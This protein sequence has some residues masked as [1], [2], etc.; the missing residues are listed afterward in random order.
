MTCTSEGIDL[1]ARGLSW[2][3][4][5]GRKLVDD[6]SFT[7]AAGER[8]A[9]VGPN[10]AGKS[11]LLRLLYRACRP[12]RGEVLLGG[13]DIW[14]IRPQAFARKV[15]VVLQENQT[16]FPFSVRDVV[17]MGRIPWRR[18]L[19]HWSDEDRAATRHALG[20]LELEDL[21]L[22]QFP[23]LSGGEKQ[24]VLIARALAQSPRLLVLDEP[25]NHLDI[26]HQLEILDILK[27]LG[28][29]VIATLHDINL[30]TGFATRAAV[31]KD[32]QMIAFGNPD[33]V[34]TR[35]TIA[36]AFDVA[37]DRH[38]RSDGGQH[39]SFSIASQR[40]ARP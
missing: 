8:L 24:R 12:D 35:G 28:I 9:I 4:K 18:G 5:G 7:L 20:H 37:A 33:D 3:P 2:A 29:T 31:M 15:A 26:R 1:A 39:F 23:S 6:I 16:V 30:A 13:E 27:G 21:A 36:S 22:R 34:L 32:G 19:G 38:A 40:G 17:L 10:G 11:T 25:S 14:S